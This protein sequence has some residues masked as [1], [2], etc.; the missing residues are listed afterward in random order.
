MS[1]LFSVGAQYPSEKLY[2][3]WLAATIFMP[4][5][6]FSLTPWHY[7]SALSQ[8][9]T[10]V[11]LKLLALR[12]KYTDLFVKLGEEATRTGHPIIRPLWYLN[13]TDVDSWKVDDQFL[14]GNDLMVAPV[15]NVDN[16][17]RKIYVPP[18]KWYDEMKQRVIDNQPDWTDY[19]IPLDQIAIFRRIP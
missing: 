12:A 15:L 7:D 2:L 3:R 14:V 5:I 18:G 1:L 10:T 11:A 13:G 6:Q 4:S 9:T 19:Q 16:D 8:T 17:Y